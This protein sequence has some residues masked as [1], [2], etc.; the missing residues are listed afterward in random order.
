VSFFDITYGA[1]L[2]QFQTILVFLML[3]PLIVVDFV[4]VYRPKFADNW[5]QVRPL[6]WAAYVTAA[7]SLVFFGIGEPLEFIY[8]QS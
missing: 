1:G 6:R 2:E 3:A 7:C 5:W 4:L 8:F